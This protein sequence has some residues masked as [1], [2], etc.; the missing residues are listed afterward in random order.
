MAEFRLPA[1]SRIRKGKRSPGAAGAR[2]G[3]H[4]PD[5]PL[6]PDLGRDPAGRYLRARPGRLRADGA[7]CADP[8][9]RQHR[10]LAHLPPLLP[11]GH[12]RLLRHEHRRHEP[13]GVHH[14]DGG[15]RRRRRPHLSA[16]A[17]AGGEGPGAGSHE[18]LRPVRLGEAVAGRPIPRRHP[19]ASGCS[20]RRSRRRSTGPRPASSA[21]AARRPARATGGTATASSVRRRCSPPTAGSSTAA[22]RRPASGWTSSR[23]RSGSIAATPS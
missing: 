22:T 15:S 7:R 12:L 21:R 19:I 23:I 3:A 5:L 4:L 2:R 14:R 11:R 9:Q 18:L 10:L 20:P 8:D 17:H 1:N 16:A 6:R 13:A